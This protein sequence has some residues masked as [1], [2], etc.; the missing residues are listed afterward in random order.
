MFSCF[1]PSAI[2]RY[3]EGVGFFMVGSSSIMSTTISGVAFVSPAPVMRP[4][5]ITKKIFFSRED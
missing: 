3:D 2:A 5:Q 4:S 1:S